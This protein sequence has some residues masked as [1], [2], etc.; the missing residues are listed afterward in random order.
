MVAF[1]AL[2]VAISIHFGRLSR[3]TFTNHDDM[4]MDRIASE[5]RNHGISRYWAEAGDLARQQGRGYFYFSIFFF[6]LPFFTEHEAVRAMM[7]SAVQLLSCGMIGVCLSLYFRPAIGLLF[8]SLLYAFL[9]EWPAHFPVTAYPVVYHLAYIMFFGGLSLF[10]CAV[11]YPYFRQRRRLCLFIAAVSLLFSYWIYEAIWVL[12]LFTSVAVVW[13]E[14]RRGQDARTNTQRWEW[15]RGMA[16]SLPLMVFWV[17]I[18]IYAVFRSVYSTTYA[19]TAISSQSATNTAGIWRVLRFFAF[20]SFPGANYV[21]QGNLVRDYVG[22]SIHENGLVPIFAS[23]G[24]AELLWIVLLSALVPTFMAVCWKQLAGPCL[25]LRKQGLW[26]AGLA[27]LIAVMIPIPVAMTVKYQSDPLYSPYISGYYS[28]VIWCVGITAAV[29]ALCGLTSHWSGR[30][31]AALQVAVTSAVVLVACANVVADDAVIDEQERAGLKW[32]MVNLFMG[33]DAFRKMPDQ[34]VVLAPSLWGDIDPHFGRYTQY[35]SDYVQGHSRRPVSFVKEV[36]VDELKRPSLYYLEVQPLPG[37]RT[38]V[39]L[40]A[41]MRRPTGDETMFVTDEFTMVAERP[42]RRTSL[43]VLTALKNSPADSAVSGSLRGN[44]EQP[45][46]GEF[47]CQG[48]ACSA[49]FHQQGM[50]LGT[51]HL[52]DGSGI[53]Q[54]VSAAVSVEFGKGFSGLER[55]SD[56]YWRWSDGSDGVAVLSV[57]NSLSS[58]VSVRLRARINTGSAAKTRFDVTIGEGDST[59]SYVASGDPFVERFVAKPG[60]TPI[61]IHSYGPRI[62]SGEDSRYLVFGLESWTLSVLPQVEVSGDAAQQGEEN[63]VEL[64]F[65]RGFFET[66]RQGD[67][68]WRWS[69]ESS[70]AMSLWNRT[71]RPME[72][73]F[74]AELFTEHEHRYPIEVAL[75]GSRAVLQVNGQPVSLVRLIQAPPGRTEITIKSSAPSLPRKPN[76]PRTFEFGIGRWKLYIPFVEAP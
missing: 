26:L 42:Y 14:G 44:W 20:G 35:W 58:P 13:L 62:R 36:G 4:F 8:V 67:N 51:A 65:G 71:S 15:L 27:A 49:I 7:A 1:A 23:L 73:M 64:T 40:F 28:F 6:I 41:P 30:A 32:R 43:S 12:F 75:P 69:T 63:P 68:Y 10:I 3:L 31:R 61:T 47:Q 21:L 34:A 24:G 48:G 2:L 52:V 18:A 16:L 17:N 55:A 46:P 57:R 56:K 72:V 59:T 39:V 37:T 9:P 60:I 29:A 50:V 70:G 66:E 53:G 45:G 22:G 19:G 33:T 38:G 74:S 11:R 25:V 54:T 76:D 5:V